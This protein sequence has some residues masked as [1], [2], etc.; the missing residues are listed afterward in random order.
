MNRRTIRRPP[1]PEPSRARTAAAARPGRLVVAGLAVITVTAALLLVWAAAAQAS[2]WVIPAMSRAY[3]TTEPGSSQTIALD[4]AGNEYQGVQLCLRGVDRKVRIS[5][6]ADSDPL[7]IGNAQLFRVYYVKV[8]TPTT[9]ARLPGR[10][11]SGPARAPRVR[12]DH[13]RARLGEPRADDALLRPRARA[14]RHAGG[15]RTRPSWRSRT[16]PKPSRSR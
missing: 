6:S 4:A 11:V 8:T 2:V 5:W 16:A 7:I 1:L 10:L 13:E 9:Q 3:P 14:A 12:R 15:R